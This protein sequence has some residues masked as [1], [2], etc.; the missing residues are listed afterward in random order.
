MDERGATADVAIVGAGVAGAATAWWL[1]RAG[2]E[3]VILERF[4]IGHPHGSSHGRSRIF[5]LSYPDVEHVRMAQESLPLWRELECE[6]GEQL[7]IPTGGLDCGGDVADRARALA[8]CGAAYELLDG[9]AA[10]RRWP[11]LSFPS[12]TTVLHQPDGAVTRAE[13]AW[14]VF[15]ATA[16]ARGARLHEG[17]E[18]LA[19][20]VDGDAVTVCTTAG[21]LRARRAVV[22]AGGWSGPLLGAAG[23]EL[24]VRVTRETVAYFAV[25][26]GL[27]LPTLVEWGQASHYALSSPGE[28]IKVGVHRATHVV[29]PDT[30]PVPDPATVDRIVAWLATRLPSV[31]PRPTR[32][33]TCIY[34]STADE[35]FILERHG[36]I[37]V[38]SACSGHGFKFAPLVG[39][40]LAELALDG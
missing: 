26:G 30:D 33:E 35:R 24:P 29:D 1:A 31:D 3:V 7:L 21:T 20:D 32:V 16:V 23:V 12:G 28:G 2:V 27:E 39:R 14:R 19:L 15:C 5:R 10:S 22:T 4:A 17:T 40:R 8:A 25:G 18:V 37:V 6:A 11:Q 9:G 13:P 38:G 34:T 36:A